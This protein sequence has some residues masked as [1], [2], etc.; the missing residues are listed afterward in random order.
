MQ[1]EWKI[2][3]RFC[4]LHFI[5]LKFL[6]SFRTC[7]IF[8]DKQSVALQPRFTQLPLSFCN[9]TRPPSRRPCR[10]PSEH[11]S[12]TGVAQVSESSS[13][14]TTVTVKSLASPCAAPGH[15]LVTWGLTVTLKPRADSR[16]LTAGVL[17]RY[18]PG[19]TVT[20][21]PT[22]AAKAVAAR[23]GK[24]SD[25]RHDPAHPISAGGPRPG[26]AVAVAVH[27]QVARPGLSPSDWTTLT[28]GHD[29]CH[30][31]DTYR[32]HALSHGPGSERRPG[33]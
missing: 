25:N 2:H 19:G 10:P 15:N 20:R 9:G 21:T 33:P 1:I 29:R 14:L 12:R 4:K 3:F 7:I 30:M 31:P 8:G 6:L 27:W 32:Y 24:R 13:E 28:P 5:I 26:G 16:T 23:P 18:R 11:N 17:L 22:A